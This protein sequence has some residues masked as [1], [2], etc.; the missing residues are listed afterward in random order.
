M[1]PPGTRIDFVKIDVEGGE[2]HVLRGATKTLHRWKP[3]V[4]FEHGLGAADYYG[5]SPEELWTL[6]DECGLGTSLMERWLRGEPALTRDEFVEQFR[7][8]R[9]YYFMAHP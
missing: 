4:I 8:G 9:N 6:L 1:I 5:A 3:V 2:L 7:T